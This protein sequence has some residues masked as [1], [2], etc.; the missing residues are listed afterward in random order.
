M[1][2]PDSR[3]S[4]RGRHR[5][6]RPDHRRRHLRKRGRSDRPSARRDGRRPGLRAAAPDG[7]PQ[8][9]DTSVALPGSS[10]PVLRNYLSRVGVPIPLQV[11]GRPVHAPDVVASVVS[12]VQAI[13]EAREG[14]PPSWTVLTV[15]PSW[16]QHR[17]AALSEALTTAVHSPVTLASAAVAAARS[18]VAADGAVRMSTLAVYDLGASTLDTAVVRIA[19]DG[20]VEH[21][22]VPPPRWHGVAAMSTTPSSATSGPASAWRPERRA[23]RPRC[24]APWPGCGPGAWRRRRPCPPTP[25]SGSTSS[26]PRATRCSGSSGRSSRNSSSSRSRSLSTPSGTPS[27]RPVY[28]LPTSMVWFSPAVVGGCR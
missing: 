17:R 10:A 19:D 26:C 14:R 15:P 6:R 27:R 4:V 11:S 9:I 25:T 3:R 20:T 5:H 16:G 13:A 21:L 2:G 24:G 7:H 12:A 1:G 23:S 18:Q 8:L 28:G 22:G